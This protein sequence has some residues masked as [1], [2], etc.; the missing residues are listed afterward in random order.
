MLKLG[1][2]L[3]Y[4]FKEYDGS[5]AMRKQEQIAALLIRAMRKVKA[6]HK[7]HL[8]SFNIGRIWED[9]IDGMTP[10]RQQYS[11]HLQSLIFVLFYLRFFVFVF[12]ILFYTLDRNVK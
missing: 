8:G 5:E 12:L 7:S 3:F 1:L 6:P 10:S 4:I 11:P 2:L 9:F